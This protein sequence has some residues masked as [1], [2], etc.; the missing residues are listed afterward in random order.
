MQAINQN[1]IGLL[2]RLNAVRAELEAK[3]RIDRFYDD[4]AASFQRYGSLTERQE[5]ALTKS[6]DRYD[7]FKTQRQARVV[8]AQVP[9]GR[10]TVTG[11]VVSTKWV[12]ND[13]G[14]ALKML[15]ESDH[16]WRV[17]G[18]MPA[19]LGDLLRD[20]NTP[21]GVKV[22]FTATIQRK[23]AD[24]GFFSRPTGGAVLKDEQPQPE[25]APAPVAERPIHFAPI[26]KDISPEDLLPKQTP[27]RLTLEQAL[28]VCTR[29]G[30]IPPAP[31]PMTHAQVEAAV[32]AP[33]LGLAA[34][35][36]AAGYIA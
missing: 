31:A 34:M 21:A 10:V 33:G 18:T 2:A 29:P 14:G 6:L 17:Y 32:K 13:F 7:Q 20:V 28:E 8:T 15:V 19:R 1:Q 11:K 12:E 23:E 4:L 5:V 26:A 25:A 9:E 3:G 35:V 22:A 24:F 16:G 36:A 27:I 30:R